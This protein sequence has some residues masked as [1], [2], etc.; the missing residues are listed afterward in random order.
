[1]RTYKEGQI[2]RKVYADGR[3]VLVHPSGVEVTETPQHRQDRIGR[4]VQRRDRLKDRIKAAQAIEELR[5]S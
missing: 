4:M 3:H 5:N 1:M 2:T